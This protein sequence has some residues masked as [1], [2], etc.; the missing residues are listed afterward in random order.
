MDDFIKRF[1]TYFEDDVCLKE[2][3]GGNLRLQIGTTVLFIELNIVPRIVGGQSEPKLST[4][5]PKNT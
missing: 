1:N 3:A 5:A 2:V 4:T